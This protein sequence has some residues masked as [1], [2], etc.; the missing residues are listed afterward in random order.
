MKARIA[1]LALLA[2][3][4]TA[5]IVVML[6]TSLKTQTQIFDRDFSLLFI[7]TLGNF[8]AVLLEANFTRYLVN[9]LI[10]GVIA[11]VITL[12]AGTMAAYALARFDF[13]GRSGLAGGSL[14][15]RTLPPA[16]LCVP[17]FVVWSQVGLDNSLTGVV[18]IYV[19]LNL[20]FTI[21]LLYGFVDQVP[22]ELEEAAA[23]DGCGPFA[24]F[25]RVILPLL[26]PGLAAAGIFTFRLAWNEFVLALV[27]TNRYTRTLPVATTLYITDVGIE[28]GKIMAAGVLIALPPV[29]FS[30][31]ASRHIIGGL[32]A[33][34]VKG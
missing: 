32:T 30:L 11:T 20:P 21:W 13:M 12:V 8:S 14:L 2:L 6:A 19:A 26:R 27:L 7:P 4:C 17:V 1:L 33:G 15:L 16:V 23:I 31:V 9:S 18:L 25:W 29:L 28:W 10:V 5:P 34:A 3:V 24:V 22:A